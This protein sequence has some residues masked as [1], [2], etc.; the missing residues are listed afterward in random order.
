MES[1]WFPFEYATM[2][3]SCM[4]QEWK[5]Y[6]WWTDF[7]TYRIFLR[8]NVNSVTCC[9]LRIYIVQWHCVRFSDSSLKLLVVPK[10]EDFLQMVWAMSVAFIYSEMCCLHHCH[11]LL[12]RQLKVVKIQERRLN[13]NIKFVRWIHIVQLNCSFSVIFPSKLECLLY[14]CVYYNWTFTVLNKMV[15]RRIW[16]EYR[17]FGYRKS[18]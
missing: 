10:D 7:D 2:L 17:R 15:W 1:T 14:K 16:K 18:W 4:T 5:V 11:Y 8:P 6:S 12:H 9:V 13:N 3:S